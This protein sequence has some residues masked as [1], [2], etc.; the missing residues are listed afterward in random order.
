V[1]AFVQDNGIYRSEDGGETWQAANAGLPSESSGI[2]IALAAR[3]NLALAVF[4]SPAG[5]GLYASLDSGASW[6]LV[7]GQG[8]TPLDTVY[9]VCIAPD[10]DHVYVGAAGGLYGSPIGPPWAWEQIAELAPVAIIVPEAG[11]GGSFYLATFNT[12]QGQGDIY[13]WRPGEK[14]QW[15]AS[16]D[17]LPSALAPHPSSTASVATYVLL[18]PTQVLAVTG[19]GQIKSLDQQP[20][21]ASALVAVSHPATE[22]KRL[23][24][25]HKDGLLEYQGAL[26]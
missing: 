25:G 16:I 2:A 1:F 26:E 19:E 6:E 22:S 14:V 5:Y 17:A 13:H 12:Q 24:L 23:L 8:E 15:L 4:I 20:G 18:F 3:S 9:A 21:F 11:D 10:G 7:G